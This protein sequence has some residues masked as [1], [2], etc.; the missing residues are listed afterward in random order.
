MSNQNFLF[1]S[2]RTL[3]KAAGVGTALTAFGAPGR[4]LAQEKLKVAAIYTVPFEQQWVS[5]LHQ[6]AN[7]AKDRGDISMSQPRTLPTP[8][9]S[10]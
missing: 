1:P 7:A 6:A 10:A 4:L 9:M 5:R 3:L 2:R 8:T